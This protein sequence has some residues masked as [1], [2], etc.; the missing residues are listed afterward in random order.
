MAFLSQLERVVSN[1][2]ADELFRS[3]QAFETF[4][5]ECLKLAKK[6]KLKVPATLKRTIKQKFSGPPAW[7][8]GGSEPVRI[9][10]YFFPWMLEAIEK[11]S[12]ESGKRKRHIF[13]EA[14][15]LYIFQ[16][17]RTWHAEKSSK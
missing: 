5:P 2:E 16:Y 11:I 3:G 7:K 1:R 6:Y 10:V 13:M 17:E 9:S 14:L 4:Y 8:L 15:E 12:R